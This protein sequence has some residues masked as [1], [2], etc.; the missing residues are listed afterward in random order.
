MLAGV[1]AYNNFLFEEFC[2]PD[3]SRLVGMA[4][5]PSTGIDDAVAGLRAAKARGAKR[6]LPLTVAGAYHSRLMASAQP[7]LRDALAGVTLSAPVM[8]V[9]ANVTAQPRFIMR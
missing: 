4:Q 7:K 6:A 2:A 8:P 3:R 5:I 9:I 1:E